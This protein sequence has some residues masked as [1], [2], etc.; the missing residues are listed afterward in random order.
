MAQRGRQ[1]TRV[2][3]KKKVSTKKRIYK[4]GKAAISES[5]G[6]LEKSK[7]KKGKNNKMNKAGR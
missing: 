7:E 4:R 1:K 5:L 3:K 2:S 6:D